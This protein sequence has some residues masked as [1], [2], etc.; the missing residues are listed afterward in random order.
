MTKP[1]IFAISALAALGALSAIPASAH[2][3]HGIGSPH[4]H[5]SEPGQKAG[6]VTPLHEVEKAMRDHHPVKGPLKPGLKSFHDTLHPLWHDYFPKKD[7]GSIKAKV[8]ELE[9]KARELAAVPLPP[10]A[11]AQRAKR[12]ALSAAVKDLT[13]SVQDDKK[14]ASAFAKVH[15][16]FEA[17]SLAARDR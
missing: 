11:R 10:S 5:L 17:L 2:P 7:Y 6:A 4:A 13:A 16:A 12:D 14:F 8:G 15:E 1:Q 9:R 3:G